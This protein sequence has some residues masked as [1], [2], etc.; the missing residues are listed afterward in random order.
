MRFLFAV[1]VLRV[2]VGGNR[3]CP[4]AVAILDQVAIPAMPLSL[5]VLLENLLRH[6]DCASVTADDIEALASPRVAAGA[7]GR[8]RS[9]RAG[10]LMQDFTGPDHRRP[11][12]R[13]VPVAHGVAHRPT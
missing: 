2:A 6:E 5:K 11:G 8:P 12:W 4:A 7:T 3:G 1:A 13:A 10:T 9:R